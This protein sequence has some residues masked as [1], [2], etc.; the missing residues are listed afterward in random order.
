MNIKHV[1][2]EEPITKNE[3]NSPDSLPSMNTKVR[4]Q[5]TNSNVSQIAYTD[6]N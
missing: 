5:A 2:K 1:K 3:K 4:P 6:T